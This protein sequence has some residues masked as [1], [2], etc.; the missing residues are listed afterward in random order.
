MLVIG[1][2][3]SIASGKS[4]VT[5]FLKELSAR[6]IDA[7]TVA[8]EVIRPGTPGWLQIRRAFGEKTLNPD[9]TV[10]RKA[11][12][13]MVF[14]NPEQMKKLNAITHPL[15]IDQI[16]AEINR[17]RSG[18]SDPPRVLVVDA[19]LLIETGLHQITDEVWVVEVPEE[20]QVQRLANRDGLTREQAL[21]RIHS[22]MPAFE[23][24]KYA[25]V[26]IDN[27]GDMESTRKIV[28]DL[29]KQRLGIRGVDN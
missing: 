29:W 26:V 25:Q 7:D 18:N 12:G 17:F 23:K 4:L 2:T 27:S 24:R 14:A 3:G 11:L 21:Q 22:Q 28:Q 9:R 10:N 5:K 15:I 1:L 6:V 20:I 13:S 8:R 19:P 16:R